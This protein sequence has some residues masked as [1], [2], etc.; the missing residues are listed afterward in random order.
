MTKKRK[1]GRPVTRKMPEPIPDTPENIALALLQGPPK[2]EW[3]YLDEYR[4][5]DRGAE[6]NAEAPE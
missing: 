1:R 4:K 2:E 6:K 5:T 3:R